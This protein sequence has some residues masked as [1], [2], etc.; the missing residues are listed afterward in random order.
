VAIRPDSSGRSWML[1]RSTSRGGSSRI[2]RPP[3]TAASVRRSIAQRLAAVIPGQRGPTLPPPGALERLGAG[4]VISTVATAVNGA[5]GLVFVRASRT[6]R[7]AP[8]AADDYTRT[9][10]SSPAAAHAAR[11]WCPHRHGWHPAVM[12]A[13]GGTQRG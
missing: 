12:T 3:T 10:R 9:A 1:N 11:S 8:F 4:L 2:A 5:V 6:H 13:Q 7:S